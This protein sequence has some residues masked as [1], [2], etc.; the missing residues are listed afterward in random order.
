MSFQTN[1]KVTTMISFQ[2]GNSEAHVESYGLVDNYLVFSGTEN[3]ERY[4]V[5]VRY[6]VNN[7]LMT[8]SIDEASVVLQEVEESGNE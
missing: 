5:A 8:L 3:G 2:D 1:S 4:S 6:V 7:N